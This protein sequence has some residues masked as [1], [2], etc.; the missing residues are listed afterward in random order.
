MFQVLIF[1]FCTMR[2]LFSAI[3]CL[4]IFIAGAQQ[5][6]FAVKG[7]LLDKD[8]GE[9][10]E[11]ASI[12]V[13]GAD[14][15][16]NSDEHGRFLLTGLCA[17]TY[18]LL[19]KHV[20]C[21]DTTFTVVVKKDMQLT[22][23]MPHSYFEIS[24]VDI[25]E[26]HVEA[27]PTVSK[28]ELESGTLFE[29]SGRSL[30]QTLDGISG[31]TSLNTGS[32]ISKPMIHGMQGYRLLIL[33]N[34]IRQ[35]GQQWGNEHAPEIDPFLAKKISVIKGASMVQ[36]GSDAM[37]GVILVEPADLPDSA[38][39]RTEINT[40]GISNGRGGTLSGILEGQFKKLKGFNWRLQGTIKQLG[41]VKAPDYFLRNTGLQERNFSY[42][43]GYHRKQWGAEIFYS[44]FNTKLGVFSGS[45]IGNLTDL[46]LALQSSKPA[47]SLAPFSYKIARPMQQVE[48]ELVKVKLH[49]HT[50]LRSRLFLQGAYQYNIRMEY[51]KHKPKNALNY[52]STK[53]DLDYRI[54]SKT[55]DL[56]WEHDN[57]K[58]FR[59]RFGVSSMYQTN[60]YL[61]RFLIPNFINKTLGIYAIERF[62]RPHFELEGGLRYDLRNLRSFYYVNNVISRPVKNFSGLSASL[63]GIIK[64]N[65]EQAV[66]LQTAYA[67][68]PPAVNEL[69]ANGL[70]HGASSIEHGDSNLV[71][72]RC[73]NSAISYRRNT[74]RLSLET[75]LFHYYFWN[76]IY[77]EPSGVT[78]LTIKGAFPGFNYRQARV[79]LYGADFSCSYRITQHWMVS[80]SAML[81]RGYNR[82]QNQ[83]LIYMP[84]DRISASISYR[85][86]S[87]RRQKDSYLTLNS[88]YLNKQWRV[89]ANVDYQNPPPGYYLVGLNMG[90]TFIFGKQELRTGISVSNLLNSKYRDY[91][92]RFRYFADAPGINVQIRLQ[93]PIKIK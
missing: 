85:I 16:V 70:H 77:L 42:Q 68:R 92:D 83:Y 56:G 32:T 48:H 89:P 87:G 4:H 27:L 51:D 1:V 49:L 76:Y 20:G 53:A 17:G 15:H 84:S 37:A 67:W 82:S 10:I 47:D 75:G 52:D 7:K 24:G 19:V 44:Q 14:I 74:R 43:L 91:L 40:V 73:L 30:A 22:L 61:G 33:N 66:N 6:N 59:G 45:H 18:S 60:V 64:I 63:G 50:G 35:E 11:F 79:D 3:L 54:T 90:S 80:S 12:T 36:Y 9:H 34:G 93:V 88:Q 8:N 71:N 39:I 31:V 26:K 86:K 69:Y 46:N 38:G 5:C 21:R 23:H 81:V 28:T 72:E 58:S 62:V 29:K 57:V 65:K 41:N 2:L 25:I 78:E 13:I 55:L